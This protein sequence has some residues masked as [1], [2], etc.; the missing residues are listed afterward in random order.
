MISRE[1]DPD[2]VRVRGDLRA[3][4]FDVDG[5]LYAQPPLRTL[6]A[7]ELAAACLARPRAGRE[8]LRV[9]RVY[10]HVHEEL[11]LQPGRGNVAARQL[12]ATAARTGVHRDRV[13]AVVQEWMYSRPLKYLRCCRRSG[14]NAALD[15]WRQGG[16][17]LGVLSDY[18]AA[19]KLQALGIVDRF[20]L[21]LCTTDHHIDAL[22]PDPAGFRRACEIWGLRPEEVLYVGDRPEVD[23]AGASAA[24]LPCVIV[25]RSPR[26]GSR[27]WRGA[28]G[29]AAVA[30]ILR[31]G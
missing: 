4:L 19:G 3:V 8:I 31:T 16:L 15:R 2:C 5:T 13:E 20:S 27:G 21:V 17:R 10:R 24:G 7:A 22:K 29:F 30:E 26:G 11:R 12:T 18:P 9:L 23:G 6:M 28:R 14:L 25:G 1:A